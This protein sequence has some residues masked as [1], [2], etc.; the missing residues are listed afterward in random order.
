MKHS[1]FMDNEKIVQFWDELSEFGA[2]QSDAALNYCLERICDLIRADN[3]Y[4]VGGVR[5][6]KGDR[7]RLDPMS[8]WRVGA[9]HLLY[10]DEAAL[11]RKKQAMRE[12]DENDVGDTTVQLIAKAGEFR[13]YTMKSGTLLSVDAFKKTDHYNFF[14]RQA[15]VEDRIWVVFPVSK[16]A[17]S[18]FCIDTYEKGRCF[19]QDELEFTSQ[20][21]RGI[22]WFHRQLLLSHGLGICL[23][24]LTPS[25]RRVKQCLLSG[26]SEK[27]IAAKL[28]LSPGTVH[29]YAVRIYRKFGVKGRTEFM[30]LW[31]HGRL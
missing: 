8:G 24:P 23:E 2:H 7:T 22:K 15:G 20:I 3:A 9:A 30:S 6:V 31:L 11:Q 13:A 17:E 21:L 29:Q 25:E 4:W 10:A 19:T 16:D 26:D 18:Y 28:S 27:E 5:V 12:P 14:Y 1:E